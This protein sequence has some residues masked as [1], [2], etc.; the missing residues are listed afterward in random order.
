MS[1]A[2]ELNPARVDDAF[3]GKLLVR[4]ILA[5]FAAG[6]PLDVWIANTIGSSSALL[7]A[8]LA[9]AA[10]WRVILDG[11]L[12]PVPR[13]LGI[14]TV[15]GGWAL[16][17][18]LWA[19]VAADAVLAIQTF[20]QL[21][22]FVWLAWQVVRSEGD[23]RAMLAGYLVGATAL[24]AGAWAQLLAGQTF[25]GERWEG[26]ARYAA[27]G[28][29][30]NDMAVTLALG[31]PIAAYLALTGRRAWARGLL[32]Y[33]PL[34]AT[35]IALS[36][37]RG[38][39]LTAATAVA[40]VT[41]WAARRSTFSMT[42]TVALAALGVA[43]IGAAV[44]ADAWTRIFTIESQL[45]GSV[46]DRTVLWRAGLRI[47]RENPILGI[48]AGGYPDA[49]Q[50]LAG[51]R[52]VAHNTPLA[53]LADFGAVGFLLFFGALASAARACWRRRGEHRAFFTAL[54]LTWLIGTASLS[55][56][57][58]KQTWFVFLL[59]AAFTA[60]PRWEPART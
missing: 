22:A 1:A 35:A 6:M 42:S 13:V 37:S 59:G 33:V 12:R 18:L 16:A 32:A 9:L 20:A 47:A 10:A 34:A 48:G 23:I 2:L 8:P 46:G 41:I 30:P 54:V 11:R 29:D 56:E 7:G 44:P 45:S 49:A 40:A 28:Y 15:F 21:L 51:I 27:A 52:T 38:G 5:A 50:R 53:V 25:S 55:W 14:L 24:V 58:Y 4:F 39:T 17:S 60:L 31:M 19:P 57:T 26:E 43:V 3:S 36:G